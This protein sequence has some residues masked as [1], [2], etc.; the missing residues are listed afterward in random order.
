[1]A[2]VN[3]ES[4]STLADT[5]L[6]SVTNRDLIQFNGSK[7]VNVKDLTVNGH[8]AFGA[9]ASIS[10]Q[11]VTNIVEESNVSGLI[12]LEVRTTSNPSSGA[13]GIITGHSINT[14]WAGTGTSS[15]VELIGLLNITR[16]SSSRSL[17]TLTGSLFRSQTD[18]GSGTITNANVINI[19]SPLYTGSQPTTHNGILFRN[20]GVSG[21]GTSAALRMEA[22]SGSTTNWGLA[23]DG[24]STNH[25]IEG[26]LRIGSSIAPT[27]KLDVTGNVKVSGDFSVDGDT[28]IGNSALDSLTINADIVTNLTFNEAANRTISIR[29]VTSGA[30]KNLNIRAG[31]TTDGGAN[32][33]DTIIDGSFGG[34]PGNVLLIPN[35]G[36]IS[37]FGVG[38]VGQSAAYT[39][40][41]VA[42]PNRT[43]LASASATTLNNNNVLAAII[44]DL[45]ATGLLG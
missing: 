10:T 34:T 7:W 24:S 3:L 15:I 43:L 32:G 13:A 42:V 31:D 26:N 27:V 4:L 41:A 29:K 25:F 19:D 16:Y 12:G 8:V 45:Q 30:G 5:L 40:N 2:K 17:S 1:M 21:I 11:I 36:G 28:T 20:Q 14:S 38:A 44:A 37:F 23:L 22:Q 35:R 18:V 33:G 9:G 39:L 6:T